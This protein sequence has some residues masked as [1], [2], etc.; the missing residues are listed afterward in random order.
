VYSSLFIVRDRA[1]RNASDQL[2]ASF[3]NRRVS[4]AIGTMKLEVMAVSCITHCIA[5]RA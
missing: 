1:C 2:I 3:L 5:Y 4:F